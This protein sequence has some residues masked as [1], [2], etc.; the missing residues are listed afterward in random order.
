V[1]PETLPRAWV[2]L[3]CKNSFC[4]SHPLHHI[5]KF[6]N[7]YGR[8]SEKKK[9]IFHKMMILKNVEADAAGFIAIFM[10]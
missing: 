1:F 8:I 10:A 6:Q 3:F 7:V 9:P 4:I 5:D 2:L